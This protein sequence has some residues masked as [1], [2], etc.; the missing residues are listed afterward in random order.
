MEAGEPDNEPALHW[1][2]EDDALDQILADVLESLARPDS[3]E[4]KPTKG[5][6]RNSAAPE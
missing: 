4:D 3:K 2:E 1:I 5:S 6:E